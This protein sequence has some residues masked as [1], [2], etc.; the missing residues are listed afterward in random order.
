MRRLLMVAL[1]G[2]LVGAMTIPAGAEPGNQIT[3]VRNDAYIATLDWYAHLETYHQQQNG[4]TLSHSILQVSRYQGEACYD[5]ALIP[6]TDNSVHWSAGQTVIDIDTPNCGRVS[7]TFEKTSKW[8]HD[9]DSDWIERDRVQSWNCGEGE[10][11]GTGYQQHSVQ[12]G[13][14]ANAN[15]AG[16]IGDLPVNS[17]DGFLFTWTW[18]TNVCAASVHPVHRRA[19]P[20]AAASLSARRNR[21]RSRGR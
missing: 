11:S 1:V 10:P 13:K 14:I 12:Q 8:S 15:V 20:T 6:G 18:H 7:L 5:L 4:E 17:S 9:Q 16:L 3:Q 2:M 19:D 21:G